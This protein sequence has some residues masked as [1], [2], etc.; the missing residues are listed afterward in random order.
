MGSQLHALPL[1]IVFKAEQVF[2]DLNEKEKNGG[3]KRRE[4]VQT[5]CWKALGPT[6]YLNQGPS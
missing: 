1:L 5:S 2:C 4:N 6:Q 3:K